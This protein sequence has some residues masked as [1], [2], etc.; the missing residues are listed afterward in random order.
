[1]TAKRMLLAGWFAFAWKKKDIFT[2]IEY[3]DGFK[4]K[5]VLVFDFKK[6]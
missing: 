2:I 6:K 3:T 5:Q 4:Q 1:M